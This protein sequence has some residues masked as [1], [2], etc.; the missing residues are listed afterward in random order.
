LL[1]NGVYLYRL[2]VRIAGD[3]SGNEYQIID[4]VAIA[5]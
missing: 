1:A 4:K 5:R 2:K 3:E